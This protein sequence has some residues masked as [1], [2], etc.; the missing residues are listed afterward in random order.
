MGV[1]K[2]LLEALIDITY[3]IDR[4]VEKGFNL[5]E[6]GEQMKY[7]HALQI[8]SQILIDLVLRVLS[9]FGN[10]LTGTN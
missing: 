10:T 1:I 8:Q 4:E 5:N 2:R 6:Q 7:L 3:R 9:K